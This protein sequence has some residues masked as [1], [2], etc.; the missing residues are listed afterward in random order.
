MQKRSSLD[1]NSKVQILSND[2]EMR[3]AHTDDSQDMRTTSEVVD[4]FGEEI[5]LQKWREE[6]FQNITTEYVRKNQEENNRESDL[7]K[8]EENTW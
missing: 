7:V 6:H 2:L 8:K 1:E 4:S 5:Q 3:L